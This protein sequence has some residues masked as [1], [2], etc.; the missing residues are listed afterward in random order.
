MTKQR[1]YSVIELSPTR[2]AIPNPV[3]NSLTSKDRLKLPYSFV[4]L[5][6]I[7]DLDAETSSA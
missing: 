5:N 1:N 2:K 7:Q 3:R 4:I 6:L